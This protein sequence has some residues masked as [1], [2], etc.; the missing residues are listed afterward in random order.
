[1]PR[2]PGILD[3]LEP[4]WNIVLPILF[5]LALFINVALFY[6]GY[7]SPDS[8]NQLS[9]ALGATQVTDWHPPIMMAIWGALIAI[10][11]HASSMLLFQLLLF[12]VSM[13]ILAWYIFR[14]TGS[15]SRSLLPLIIG[16]LPPVIAISGVIWKDV[17]MA[18]SFSLAAALLLVAGTI[19]VKRVVKITIYIL[20]FVLITYGALL[21]YNALFAAI[22]LV[23]VAI[24]NLLSRTRN[25]PTYCITIAVVV[26]IPLLGVV[27][28]QVIIKAKSENPISSVMLDD[29]VNLNDYSEIAM[30][31]PAGVRPMLM[32]VKQD[33]EEKQG[34]VNSYWLCADDAMRLVVTSTGYDDL[35]S[36]WVDTLMKRPLGYIQYRI[37]TFALFIFVPDRYTY[38]WQQ[39]IEANTLG[40]N[41]KYPTL[42]AA[43]EVYVKSFGYRHFSF[44]FEPWFWIVASAG[45]M[46]LA[47]KTVV[48]KKYIIMLSVSSLL[49]IFSYIPVVVAADYRYIYWAAIAV[50]IAAVLFIIEYNATT[51]SSTK[52][53]ER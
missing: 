45:L 37:E 7:M 41:V 5:I 10:T 1:M 16:F 13:F 42:G 44:L 15:M 49:Y 32:A 14:S 20:I 46:L 9:Q 36:Y 22:P 17:Q 43:L 4:H 38:I 21:R 3:K 50:L 30:T 52:K 18:Y 40:Q 34:R 23:F 24:D 19:K 31:A 12:W 47:R 27:L 48:Y 28:N 11:G 35:R 39:G 53:S 51:R 8:L 26:T 29:V 2:K 25:W 6:P 33:C